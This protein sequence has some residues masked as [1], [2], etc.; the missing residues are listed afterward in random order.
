MPR[1]QIGPLVVA[2]PGHCVPWR[3]PEKALC[4]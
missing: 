4:V 1:R 2:W 3:A